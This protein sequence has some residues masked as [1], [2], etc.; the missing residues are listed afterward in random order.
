MILVNASSHSADPVG[1]QYT[2]FCE[3]NLHNA[4]DRIP[5]T[6]TVSF[7]FHCHIQIQSSILQHCISETSKNEHRAQKAH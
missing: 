4:C 7:L 3:G 1:N 5:S 2:G 6:P